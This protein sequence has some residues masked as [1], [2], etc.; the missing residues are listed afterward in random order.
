M[1]K[2]KIILSNDAKN[3][4]KFTNNEELISIDTLNQYIHNDKMFP[5]EEHLRSIWDNISGFVIKCLEK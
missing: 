1:E 4:T 5:A 3:L 2:E